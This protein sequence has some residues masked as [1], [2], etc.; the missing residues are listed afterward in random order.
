M[1]LASRIFRRD[2]WY[3]TSPF[4]YRDAVYD[5]K[6]NKVSSAGTHN[7]CDY[8]TRGQKW[9]QYALEDGIVLSAG[10]DNQGA[11]F[12]WIRYPRI[13]IELLHY[14]LDSVLVKTGQA[15]T[16]NTIIG[17]TGTTG[18]STGIHL[19]LGMRKIGS[20]KYY[21]PHS[22]DYSEY[23]APVTPVNDEQIYVV[24]KGDTLSHIANKYGTTYQKLAEYNNISNPNLIRVGQKIKIPGTTQIRYY[25][26]QPGDNLSKIASKYKTTWQKIYDDNKS[27]IGN[28]PNL[29]KPGQR[30]VIK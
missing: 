10:R 20:T 19:H 17:Y 4:G 27:I 25:V 9:T 21:D 12:A 3:V 8:G 29:I 26:V 28:N 15:V 18:P 22:Y 13:G 6:G 30:L 1:K 7:G 23:V 14:H 2:D 5:S 24:V 16:K 11:I